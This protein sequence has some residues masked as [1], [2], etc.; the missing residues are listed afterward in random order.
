MRLQKANVAPSPYGSRLAGVPS[1]P[2]RSRDAR[3]ITEFKGRLAP[4]FSKSVVGL[5]E[6]LS[7]GIV[8]FNGNC[9]KGR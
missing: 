5:L 1:A 2:A 9:Q 6:G 4:L 7:Q 3:N 8:V